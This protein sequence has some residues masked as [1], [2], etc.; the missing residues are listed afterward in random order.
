MGDLET[1]LIA[2]NTLALVL[3]SFPAGRLLAWSP[4]IAGYQALVLARAVR[5]GTWSAVLRGWGAAIRHLPGTLRARRQV[6]A[7]TRDPHALDAV[8]TRFIHR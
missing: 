4:L 2:R 1:E 7:S 6:R 5:A 3:K 8:M